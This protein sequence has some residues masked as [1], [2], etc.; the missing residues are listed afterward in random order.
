M[1]NFIH[2]QYSI[3]TIPLNLFMIVGPIV[4]HASEYRKDIPALNIHFIQ[5]QTQHPFI[6]Q[7]LFFSFF[8]QIIE[9]LFP[10]GIQFDFSICLKLF[11]VENTT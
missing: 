4:S 6:R 8:F 11:S 3:S 2:I 7:G 5:C 10:D 9:K 1:M